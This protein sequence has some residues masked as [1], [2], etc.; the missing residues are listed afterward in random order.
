MYKILDKAPKICY[1]NGIKRERR[2]QDGSHSFDDH[3]HIN[4]ATA[5][6]V[7]IKALK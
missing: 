3:T 7:L 4:L 6:L 1:N 2:R 5:I